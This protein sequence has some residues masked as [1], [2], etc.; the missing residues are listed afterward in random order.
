MDF[1]SMSIKEIKHKDLFGFIYIEFRKR[2][3]KSHVFIRNFILFVE[4][5]IIMG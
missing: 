5:M 3:C 2:I 4:I 1:W